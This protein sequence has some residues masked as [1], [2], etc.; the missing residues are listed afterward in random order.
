MRTTMY[1]WWG[2]SLVLAAGMIEGCT[3]SHMASDAPHA[4]HSMLAIPAEDPDADE[5]EAQAWRT[6]AGVLRRQGTAHDEVYTIVVPRDD[7]YVTVEEMVV[8]T[9]AGI[10]SRFNFYHCSCGKTSVVGEFVVTDY[11]ANDVMETLLAK[12][13]TVASVAPFLLHEHPRLLSVHFKG[14]GK[15]AAVAAVLKEALSYTGKERDAPTTN[16]SQ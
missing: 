9:A 16:I 7:L 8:P 1:R 2:L 12:Q 13:F 14:E 4:S 10:E 6:I 5:T 11:E 15:S 3:G